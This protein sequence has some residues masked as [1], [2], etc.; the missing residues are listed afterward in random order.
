MYKLQQRKNK[1]CENREKGHFIGYAIDNPS[2]KVFNVY[3]NDKQEVL[4][5]ATVRFSPE[6]RVTHLY[7]DCWTLFDKQSDI[8]KFLVNDIKQSLKW[9]ELYFAIE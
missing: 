7:M 3:G 9:F 2:A 6:K 1:T 5:C 8:P 4:S